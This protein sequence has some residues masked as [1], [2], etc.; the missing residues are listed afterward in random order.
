MI[1]YWTGHLLVYIEVQ[2]FIN[3]LFSVWHGS[4]FVGQHISWS[5]KALSMITWK[6][7]VLCLCWDGG[8]FEQVLHSWLMLGQKT[9]VLSKCK[10]ITNY[11][12][13]CATWVR[14]TLLDVAE[15]S[16]RRWR[17]SDATINHGCK[18]AKV[19]Q[20][21]PST[22][23]W[24][25]VWPLS[26]SEASPSRLRPP[27][28]SCEWHL[29]GNESAVHRL[30]PGKDPTGRQDLFLQMLLSDFT[31]LAAAA[32]PRTWQHIHF[33]LPAAQ[34]HFPPSVTAHLKFSYQAT[35]PLLWNN[36]SPK[37][38]TTPFPPPSC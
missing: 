29:W 37:F 27:E 3:S 9:A 7:Q 18:S 35:A 22:V 31:F 30:L 26:W 11:F 6:T 12:T 38:C 23:W 36:L 16:K 32:V 17:Y 33:F 10:I 28:R 4:Q 2:E 24:N 15:A 1:N 8:C 13:I 19:S 14:V 5:V 21:W 25:H 34:S 20:P